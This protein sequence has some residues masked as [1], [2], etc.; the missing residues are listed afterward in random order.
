MSDI[1]QYIDEALASE[2]TFLQELHRV[3]GI[4]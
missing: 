4:L 3:L 2:Y 1:K